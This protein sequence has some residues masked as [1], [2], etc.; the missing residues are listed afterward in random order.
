MTSDRPVAE[1]PDGELLTLS[2]VYEMMFGAP[3][4]QWLAVVDAD[5]AP[6]TGHAVSLVCR[7]DDMDGG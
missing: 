4:A 7:D 6:T 2:E 1:G 5:G 3:V